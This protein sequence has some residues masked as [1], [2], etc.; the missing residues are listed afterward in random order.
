MIG[1]RAALAELGA[2]RQAH[3]LVTVIAAAGST[4]RETGAK[5]VVT[6]AGQFGSIGGGHL[7]L[8]ALEKARAMLA[9]KS[10]THIEDFALGPKLGQCCGGAVTLLIESFVPS[11]FTLALFGAG[12]VAK[13]IIDVLGDIDARVLWIDGRAD[14]FPTVFPEHVERVI[15]D[16]A[17]AVAD[18][19]AGAIALVMT[20]SHDLDLA[21]L[22]RL[23]K[24]GDM[25]TIGVIGSVTKRARF[26]A[27]LKRKGFAP[28][29]VEAIRCPIGLPGIA[30]K[31]P[32]EI[33]IAVAAELLLERDHARSPDVREGK[34]HVRVR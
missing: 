34:D 24:R 5:M 20:H 17:D 2:R 7:E 22:E 15:D 3:A 4:P 30:G 23:L 14:Q 11:A 29:A 6:T 21:I 13:A 27:R 32:R 9:N 16:P 19:P 28:T 33:A 10:A 31:R 1:W 18:L 25:K 8:K 26:S 12:H